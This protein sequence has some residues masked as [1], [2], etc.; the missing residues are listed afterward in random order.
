[1]CALQIWWQT[2]ASSKQRWKHVPLESRLWERP[3]AGRACYL[4]SWVYRILS[5]FYLPSITI[6]QVNKDTNL[7]DMFSREIRGCVHQTQL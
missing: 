5:L 6:L 4:S 1:M 7:L 3:S 2:P